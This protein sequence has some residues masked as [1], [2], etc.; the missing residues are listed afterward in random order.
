MEVVHGRFEVRV[1]EHHLQVPHKRTVL[2]GVG[3]EGVAQMVRSQTT[4]AAAICRRS[5]GPLEVGLVATP[6][7]KLVSS[8]ITAQAARRKEPRPAL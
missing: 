7:D 4:Q 2:Q 8:W 1:A 3:S 6:A 5:N